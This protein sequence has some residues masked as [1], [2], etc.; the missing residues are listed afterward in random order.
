MTSSTSLGSLAQPRPHS[1][2]FELLDSLPVLISNL[3]IYASV[4]AAVTTHDDAGRLE[5]VL[6]CPHET[7]SAVELLAMFA[8]RHISDP[9]GKW[10]LMPV[11]E[12]WL[13]DSTCDVFLISLPY[14]FGPD[15]QICNLPDDHI[16][17]L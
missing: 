7:P 9:L 16:H 6:T 17:I 8:H 1:P 12:P 5:F 14:P 10:H 13:D 15:L 2:N 3:W 4:G 11:G